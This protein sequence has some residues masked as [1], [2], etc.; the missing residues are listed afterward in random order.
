MTSRIA[1]LVI[2]AL[3]ASPA[4][5]AQQ[6]PAQG[7]A[8]AELAEL[9]I[10][11]RQA[12]RAFGQQG[13][14]SAKAVAVQKA[15]LAEF[16]A[17]LDTLP[18]AKWPVADQVDWYVLQTEMNQLDFDQRI[19]RAWS[20]DPGFYVQ[21]A[22]AGLPQDVERISPEQAAAV[23]ARLERVPAL[24][25]QAKRNL[26]RSRRARTVSWRCAASSTCAAF[27]SSRPIEIGSNRWHRRPPRATP[28]SPKRQGLPPARC[29]NTQ[30]G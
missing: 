15:Q 29:Q 26:S 3:T 10:D 9:A 23:A 7:Q 13:D 28:T 24:F 5:L 12:R 19:R 20:R 27:A 11:F 16:R 8:P 25:D 18:R 1:V 22:L 17:R 30:P 6:V 4:V 21:Q 2:A 14:F